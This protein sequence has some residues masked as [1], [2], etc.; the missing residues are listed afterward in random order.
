MGCLM[1]GLSVAHRV[2]LA[3]LLA[4]CSETVLGAVSSAVAA[5]PGAKAAE[6]RDLLDEERR[7]RKRRA[8]VFA[9]IAPMFRPRPDGIAA[10]TFP[11]E[12]LARLWKAASSREPA[13]LPRL[14]ENSPDA[15]AVANRICAAAAN[16]VRDEPALIWPEALAPA[17]RETALID[18][19][20]SLDLT[21]L[22]RRALPSIQIWLKRPDG[23]QLAELRLLVKDCAVIHAD[24]AWR[25]MEMMFAHLDDAV[26]ILRI[27]TRTSAASD[28]EGFLSASELADFVDRLLVGVEERVTRLAAYKPSADPAGIQQAISDLDWCSNV[29]AELDV[30]LTL[31]P[32]STWGRTLR[33]NRLAV[34][35]WLTRLFRSADKAVDKAL[36]LTKVQTAGRMTRLAPQLDAPVK[37]ENPDAAFALLKLV[38]VARG[39]A[40]TFGCEGDRKL[41]TEAVTARLSD[42]ADKVLAA[43]NDGEAPDEAQ[44]L[45]LTSI[46]A[47]YLELIDARDAARAVRRR[48]AVAGAPTEA[49]KASSRAA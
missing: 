17:R 7:D 19:G 2:A 30:T 8:L 4:R 5:L 26:L 31:D 1:P 24:G 13:L 3:G 43:V 34:A 35:G 28:R 6:L 18:L 14:D 32:D 42:Y 45:K 16:I 38:G 44:A 39:A 11:P 33:D 20:T 46:A 23:D 21:H 37:G 12:V 27:L 22:A 9:P 29:L 41:L 25:L 10:T 49:G 40:A 47:R 15:E 48:A 36:P